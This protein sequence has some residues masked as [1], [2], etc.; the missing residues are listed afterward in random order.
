MN[1]RDD[2]ELFTFEYNGYT[3]CFRIMDENIKTYDNGEHYHFEV[4]VYE[5]DN[6]V[7]SFPVTFSLEGENLH[8]AHTKV[9]EEIVKKI[10]V[11][12]GV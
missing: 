10:R 1:K 7:D 6:K 9:T 11:D 5:K 3:F 8:Y 2:M 12:S 4:F